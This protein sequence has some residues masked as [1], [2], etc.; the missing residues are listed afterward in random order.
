ME[1]SIELDGWKANIRFSSSHIIPKHKKC[2]HL[3]GHTYALHAKV[4]GKLDENGMIIDFSEL[5]S[6]LREIADK[7][8]HKILI[9]EKSPGIDRDKSEIRFVANDKNYVFPQEDCVF[10]PIK[11]TTA[12]L[13][14]EYVMKELLKKMKLSKTVS[15]V[16][17]GVDEGV[18]QGARVEKII[19]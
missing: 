18:G 6:V 13:L 3:H 11:S 17:I 12:E 16:I 9:P 5:K 1:F 19:K 2:G 10:L 4:C 15:K 7:L 8:D 14:A